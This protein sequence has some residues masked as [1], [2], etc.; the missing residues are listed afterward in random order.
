M[1]KLFRVALMV[2]FLAVLGAAAQAGQLVVGFSANSTSG[3]FFAYLDQQIRAQGEKLGYKMVQTDAQSDFTKQISDVE[4]LLSQGI[5]F[6]IINPHDPK[7][8]LQ[9]VNKAA[10]AGVPVIAVD[11]LLDDSAPV[12]TRIAAGNYSAAYLLGEYAADAMGNEPIR[13]ALICFKP[14]NIANWERRCGFM[15]GIMEKQLA[16]KGKGNLDVVMQTWAYATDEGGLKCME[17]T[18]TARPDVNLV[19]SDNSL[20]IKGILNAIRA[21][22]RQDIKVFCNDASK[23]EMDA[24]KAG[25][26]Q[27]SA[28]NSPGPLVEMIFDVIQRYE[29]GERVFPGNLT[30]KSVAINKSNVD[31]YYSFGF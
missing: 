16:D 27:G 6:L 31:Q 3:N 18:L 4:D 14:G 21:A 13:A 24:I 22:G 10:A 2:A 29:K 1:K 9:M 11:S 30:P 7:A 23:F 26:I 28:L 12:L 15:A 5:N 19:F 20:Q 25:Q 17:D 8:G